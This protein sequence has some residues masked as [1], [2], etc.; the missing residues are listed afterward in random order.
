[1]N[2][3]ST[4]RELAKSRKRFL[5][6][7]TQGTGGA[8]D[9][10]DRGAYQYIPTFTGN[11]SEY[12]NPLQRY[13]EYAHLY[14]TAWE[15]QKIVNIPVDDALRKHWEVQD[16]DETIAQAIEKRLDRMRFKDA[17]SRALKLE[18]L[19]GGSVLFWGLESM[20]DTPDEAY[21]P[22]TEKARPRFVN[23]IPVSRIGRIFWESDPLKETYMRP[24]SFSVDGKNV[25]VSRCAVFDGDPLFAPSDNIVLGWR[26]DVSGFG[27]SKLAPIW[28]DIIKARGSRHAAYQM[29]QTNNALIMAVQEL[30]GLT[31][32]TPGQTNIATLK[33][34]AN[35]I[36]LYR[37]AIIDKEKVDMHNMAAQ[38][39]SVPELLILFLQV[40]S[41]ASDIPATRFLG[42]AP[43]GLNATGE[44]DLEN[45]YNMIDSYQGRKIEPAII[46]AYD[47]VGYS[48]YPDWHNIRKEMSI[49]F[50]PLWNIDE[51]QE[52]QRAQINLDNAIKAWEA[53]AITDEKFIQELNAKNVFS[54]DLEEEGVDLIRPSDKSNPLSG[55]FGNE[56]TDD[57]LPIENRRF[58]EE[59]HP[60]ADDGKF[61]SKTG[62]TTKKTD[63]EKK[64]A[65][66]QKFKEAIAHHSSSD[67]AAHIKAR[68]AGIKV[69]PAWTDLKVNPKGS[70]VLAKGKDTKGRA[71][72]VYSGAHTEKQSAKKFARLKKFA[73]DHP[74][75][76]A[77]VQKDF[78]SSDEAKC[79]YLINKT[80]FRIGGSGDTGAEKQAFGASTLLGRH[81]KIDGNKISFSF[82][83][84][85]GVL[86]SH[87]IEDSQ[88]AKVF[89]NKKPDEPLFDTT[90]A[91]VR[92]YIKAINKNY[93]PKDFR[94]HIATK[95]AL[96]AISKMTPP[97][98]E[99]E[100]KRAIMEVAT[101]VSKKLGNTPKMA[102]DSYIDPA[103]F[104]KWEA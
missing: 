91:K 96:Y 65:S 88:L 83:G 74:K 82:T 51:L 39:G 6:T 45:Y 63:A 95:E 61:G 47:F 28:D 94:T 66:D 18:R 38:F 57:S 58:K 23:A 70:K 71:Q 73:N 98:N 8:F 10:G 72:V 14:I 30:A 31:A 50:P 32:T 22:A 99:K 93:K 97:K 46:Q 64:A 44:S 90:D 25:H 42:Q 55:L 2:R 77:K 59:E 69:P 21:N 76:M 78:N 43:G 53:G 87:T 9:D 7:F 4:I 5:N 56:S 15:A 17:L 80:G 68:E 35:Q 36:S 26:R 79:L 62:K 104:K 24:E 16:I 92:G 49:K 41:A 52:A 67:K 60:R 102:K 81:I 75:I 84:K 20:S 86:Q 37:A 103:V 13:Q 34:I 89:K 48:M 12:A 40:I 27:D 33:Q 1:M 3:L 54:V 19:L 11:P 101:I 85:K 29:I 100:K